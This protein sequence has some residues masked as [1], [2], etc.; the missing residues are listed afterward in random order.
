MGETTE[1]IWAESTFNPWWGCSKVS[2][3]CA[4]CYAESFSKRVGFKIWGRDAERRFFGEKHWAEPLR[5]DAAARKRGVMHRVFCGSMCDILEDGGDLIQPRHAVFI[6]AKNTPN[7]LWLFLT[8]RPENAFAMLPDAWRKEW[9]RN[10]MLGVTIENRKRLDERI[11]H[12]AGIHRQFPGVSMFASC[13]PL[14]SAL[15]WELSAYYN[16]NALKYF[17]WVIAGGESG[18]GH[19]PM[20]VE[21]V[22]KLRND[23]ESRTDMGRPWPVPFLF[24]QWGGLHPKDGGRLLDGRTWDG[25]P[26]R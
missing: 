26:R 8:K 19:R 5:W 16:Y 23:C 2:E 3:G 1:I 18:V 17:D 10:A 24:K 4:H 20:N 14:L 9:P 6:L 12:V 25:V 13:E 7:L 15:G 21:W 11:I 22:R